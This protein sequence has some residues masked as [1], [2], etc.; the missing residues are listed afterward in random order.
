MGLATSFD[1]DSRCWI[2]HLFLF[3]RRLPKNQLVRLSDSSRRQ[4]DQ[5]IKEQKQELAGLKG[6]G[7]TTNQ[8]IIKKAS[9][10][11]EMFM[12]SDTAPLLSNNE[13]ETYTDGEPFFKQFFC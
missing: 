12:N 13:V 3:G 6:P 2:Y 9:G 5:V 7:L 8:Q 1:F 11:I 10:L 4:V